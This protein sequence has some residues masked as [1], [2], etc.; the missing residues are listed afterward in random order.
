MRFEKAPSVSYRILCLQLFVTLPLLE[1]TVDAFAPY[2]YCRTQQYRENPL[3]RRRISDT[4]LLAVVQDQRP[5]LVVGKIIVDE[6]GH[7]N[8]TA[9]PAF[10]GTNSSITVGGG[11]P[12]AAIGASLALAARDF[13]KQ[14]DDDD[15]N[16]EGDSEESVPPKQPVYF[17]A[18]VGGL[19][20]GLD[21][22]AA[23]LETLQ[24]ALLHPP[25]L[26]RGQGL[27]TPRIRLWH[28]NMPN[29]QE[30]TLR[31]FGQKNVAIG[32]A[33]GNIA[34]RVALNV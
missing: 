13:I 32:H 29:K 2:H 25:V 19:D 11:G 4:K 21:E 23:L 16:K 31:W 33:S 10:P 24:H 15:A 9:V 6:Y 8:N 26:L 7:P 30:Q 27:V 1:S 18:P 14:E 34:L 3:I 12:Q 20:F 17:M 5:I 28:E 22:E